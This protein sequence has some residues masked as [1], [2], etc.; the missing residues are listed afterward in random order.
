MKAVVIALHTQNNSLMKKGKETT[1]IVDVKEN[2]GF[3]V[4]KKTEKIITRWLEVPQG[5]LQD[6]AS[7]SS[8]KALSPAVMCCKH[9][10]CKWASTSRSALY[11]SVRG[12]A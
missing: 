10:Y 3:R 11:P 4:T 2:Q 12:S 9:L 8:M 1:F 5:A 7:P 6:L